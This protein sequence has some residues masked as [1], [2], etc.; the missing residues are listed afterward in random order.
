MAI[1]L[2]LVLA[3]GVFAGAEIAVIAVRR[4]RLRQLV[5]EGRGAARA[6]LGLRNDPERF[7]ATVQVGITVVGAAA[8]AFGGATLAEGL[9]PWLERMPALARYAGE[10]S[11]ALVVVIVSFLQLVLGELVPKSIA[12]RS[13]EPYA[14]FVAR[15]LL[16][17]AWVARPLIW[18][19]TKTSNLFLAP[20][21]DRTTF[22]ESRLSAEEL[23]QMVQ[24]A[25]QSGSL[26]ANAGEIAGRALEFGELTAVD[27]MVPRNRVDAIRRDASEEELRRLVL[28][29]GHARM[30]VYDGTLDNIVGYVVAKDLLGL[31][32]ERGL[33]VLED[34]VRPPYFVPESA[35]AVTVL[36]DMQK[37]H[38]KLAIVVDEHGGVAGLVTL[39]DLVEE[40]VGDIV[41]EGE[42]DEPLIRP[43]ADG[44]AVVRGD[45]PIR[46]VNRALDL[47]LE[48]GEGFTT[49]A[50][51]SIELAGG[52]PSK[53]TQLRTPDGAVLEVLDASPRVVRLLRVTPPPRP[54]HEDG[55]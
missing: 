33:V 53:G 11:I 26:D 9:R 25:A 38:T 45:V 31:A 13:S 51:L 21:G 3:N 36:R 54:A 48:E 4:T 10:L 44:S 27:V 43:A 12:L 28:E 50:G 35:R 37:R 6:V 34:V 15:P 8:A 20:F 2:G 39:E 29:E 46:E 30:P 42:A 19:L 52:I 22:S 47:D 5:D 24:D 32:W 49:V 16:G 40:L 18:I 14:L 23:A 17:L 1:I 55:E 7:L 41:G